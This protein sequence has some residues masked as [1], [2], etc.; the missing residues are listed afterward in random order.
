MLF[1]FSQVSFSTEIKLSGL[2]LHILAS[3]FFRL[4]TSSALTHQVSLPNSVMLRTHAEDNLSFAPKG[5]SP[6][7]KKD[8]KSLNLL[9]P[10]LIFV[11]T[12]SITPPVAHTVSPR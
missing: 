5:K 1:N 11:A 2:V 7:A 3:V 8:T 6:L 4:I 12:L 9:H 10:L